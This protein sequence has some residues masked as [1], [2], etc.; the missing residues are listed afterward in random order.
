MRGN[1]WEWCQDT[2]KPY[3]CDSKTEAD[4]TVRVLR[5]GSWFEIN[6]HRSAVRSNN[7][8]AV[9]SILNGFRLAQD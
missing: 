1:V 7:G 2:Y 3:P 4:N 6:D 5:G 8:P 9:G